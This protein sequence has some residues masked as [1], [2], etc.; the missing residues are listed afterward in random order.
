MAS[1]GAHC[2]PQSPRVV[3][4][5]HRGRPCAELRPSCPAKTGGRNSWRSKRPGCILHQNVLTGAAVFRQAF[6]SQKEGEPSPDQYSKF[7]LVHPRECV[8]VC[9][10]SMLPP[11]EQPIPPEGRGGGG[12]RLDFWKEG[13]S[14]FDLSW[15]QQGDLPSMGCVGDRAGSRFISSLRLGC[16]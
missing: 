14:H 12:G 13:S 8:C 5:A 2:R 15:L 1:P 11:L 10:R 16:D 6:S 7:F 4:C 9:D 3:S